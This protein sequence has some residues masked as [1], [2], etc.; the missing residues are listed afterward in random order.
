MSARL[1]GVLLLLG[2]VLL[3]ACATNGRKRPS[4]DRATRITE[5]PLRFVFIDLGQ[6]D[7]MLVVYRGKSLLMDSGESRTPEDAE[8]YHVVGQRLEELTGKR[9]VDYFVVTHYHRD[10]I[11]DEKEL[12]GLFGLI[13]LDGVTVGTLI[14]R[15][16]DNYG[17][18][19]EKG[20]T[21]LGYERAVPQWLQ[22][23]KVLAHKVIAVNEKVDLGEGLSIDVVATN[24]NGLLEALAKSNPAELDGWPASENDY[25]VGLKFTFG[26]FELFAGGDL[27]GLTQHRDFGNKQEGYHDIESST[28]ERV[29]DVEVYR[30]DHHG[31]AHSSNECFMS[32]LHPEVSIISTGENNYGH[33]AKRAY[34]AMASSGKVFIT[35]GADKRVRGHVEK[36]IVGGDITVLVDEA[37]KRYSVNGKDLRAK[38]EEQE[39]SQRP[40][41]PLKCLGENAIH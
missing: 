11:G 36:S 23:K 16:P 10:H 20:E 18:S 27:T 14:D 3:P 4:R 38:S 1:G 33:P 5:A 13:A 24:G 28:A 30:A 7:A 17:E 34:D 37:G 19:G 9:H 41:R 8:K 2:L 6:A 22:T 12:T 31:S 32:V 25:S 29:G 39:D 21:Q 40:G 35:G 26:D 15:G